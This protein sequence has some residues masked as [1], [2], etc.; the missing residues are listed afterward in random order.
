MEER[1]FQEKLIEQFQIAMLEERTFQVIETKQFQS[2]RLKETFQVIWIVVFQLDKQK[3]KKF[4]K[5]MMK[6]RLC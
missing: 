4:L 6:A 2:M 3:N 5:R 1:T